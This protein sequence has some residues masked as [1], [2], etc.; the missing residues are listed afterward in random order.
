MRKYE[1][2]IDY[3][4]FNIVIWNDSGKRVFAIGTKDFANIVFA[5]EYVDK[6][7]DKQNAYV[8]SEGVYRWK[9]SN[10]VPFD[11]M[12]ECWALDSDTLRKCQEAREADDSAFIADYKERMKDYEPSDEELYEMRAA[13]GNDATVV[14]V[15]TG[16]EI[17]LNER[18]DNMA[19]MII[20]KGIQFSLS[21]VLFSSPCSKGGLCE[22]PNCS[23]AVGQWQKDKRWYITFGHAG[24]NS[25]ANNRNG[26]A[27]EAKAI[28]A[29][30]K[31]LRK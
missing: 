1:N 4:G 11:D 29:M 12:L 14:N 15:I 5:K 25:R 26:Y 30:R 6:V 18:G 2:D 19:V 24:F 3:K 16:Q 8:D 9:S 23:T 10:R 21:D 28:A 13:F 22:D 31:Y 20:G 17:N 7:Q 27:S